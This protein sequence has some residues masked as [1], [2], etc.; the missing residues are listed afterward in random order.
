[1]SHLFLRASHFFPIYHSIGQETFYLETEEMLDIWCLDT[2]VSALV[3]TMK[4]LLVD[5]DDAGL[6]V[7]IKLGWR[8]FP[9]YTAVPSASLIFSCVKASPSVWESK[10]CWCTKST[11]LC[12]F[13]VSGLS[14]NCL[15][16][17]DMEL[18]TTGCCSGQDVQRPTD[19]FV[20]VHGKQIN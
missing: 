4:D 5:D 19:S 14:L 12:S 3:N 6:S 9:Q 18:Q 7:Q 20:R 13:I 8:G 11:A 16:Q 17:Y 1:M 15:T 2:S 10:C